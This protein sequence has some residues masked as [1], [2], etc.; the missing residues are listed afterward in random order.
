MEHLHIS[1]ELVGRSG[2][3]FGYGRSFKDYPDR[4]ALVYDYAFHNRLIREEH[5]ALKLTVAGE[6]KLGAENSAEMIQLFRFWL[7]LYKGAVP[8][9]SSIVYWTG[10]CAGD[11]STTESLFKQIGPFIQPF[12]YDT[13]EDIYEKRI[14]RMM[15]RPRVDSRR[16][17]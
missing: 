4:F 15:Q 3:R 11:W 7:R 12:Y 6:E 17:A 16:C 2:W 13:A 1:E 14:I 9:L 8:N 10:E 5:C